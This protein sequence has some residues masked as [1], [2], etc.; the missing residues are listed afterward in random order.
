MV[1]AILPQVTSTKD[2]ERRA[3]GAGEFRALRI[4]AQGAATSPG[5]LCV[6]QKSCVQRGGHSRND[7]VGC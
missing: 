1:L 3:N 5:V 6:G 4:K 2:K 7:H